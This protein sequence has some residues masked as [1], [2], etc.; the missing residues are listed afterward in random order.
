MNTDY[1]LSART[2]FKK[3]LKTILAVSVLYLFFLIAN[4]PA[5]IVIS[6]LNLPANIK[7][8]SISGTIWSG[9]VNNLKYAGIDLGSVSWNLQPLSLL[10]G[11]VSADVS[12]VKDQQYIKTWAS[13][14]SSGKVELEDTRFLIDL[15]SLQPLTYGMPFSYSG[16]AS[17]NFPVT[18]FHK[19][20]HVGI[21]G[22]LSFTNIEMVSPQRQSFGG[23]DIDFRAED[24]GT[25]SGRLNDNN[26]LLNVSGQL[27]LNKNGE[28][29]ISA[30]LAARE[31]GSSLEN[32]IS[33]L[34]PKDTAGRVLLNS[35]LNLWY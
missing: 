9:K 34:G 2:F 13:L 26:E 27:S 3:N 28:F 35:R 33:F 5:N 4:L 7:L 15:S 30:T 31:K 8:T 1:Y 11:A 23:L 20:D 16:Q 10:I 14:S 19:N 18:Y 12:I 32:V 17:G 24:N 21:N 25:T 29:I 22:K 6:V